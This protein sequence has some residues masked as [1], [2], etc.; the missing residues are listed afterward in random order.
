MS[1]L[2]KLM[3]KQTT[4]E[5][6]TTSWIWGIFAALKFCRKYIARKSHRFAKS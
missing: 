6:V 1:P 4:Q 3:D 2:I 5:R